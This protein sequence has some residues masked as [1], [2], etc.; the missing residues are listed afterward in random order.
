MEWST[1]IER[2]FGLE[3]GSFAG[4]YEAWLALVH[5]D[6][7]AMMHDK[8]AKTLCDARAL[9]GRVP[10]PCGPTAARFGRARA[11]T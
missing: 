11:A 1:N 5:P 6:D 10:L 9:R 7:R 8:V 2:I 4:T 3:S